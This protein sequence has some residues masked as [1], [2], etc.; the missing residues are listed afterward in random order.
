MIR[1]TNL[2]E[3]DKGKW[4]ACRQC[5]TKPQYGRIKG[6]NEEDIFVVFKCDGHWA[7]YYNYTA[8]AVAPHKLDFVTRVL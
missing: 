2:T 7:T 6:W 8:E 5:A 3:A 1:I 4:V